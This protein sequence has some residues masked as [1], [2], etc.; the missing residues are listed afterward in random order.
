MNDQLVHPATCGAP[1]ALGALPRTLPLLH[2][3]AS[4]DGLLARN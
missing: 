2:A 4:L 3:N 1:R